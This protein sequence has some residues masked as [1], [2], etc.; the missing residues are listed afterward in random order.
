MPPDPVRAAWARRILAFGIDEITDSGS[1]SRSHGS[2]TRCP[3]NSPERRRH[4]QSVPAGAAGTLCGHALSMAPEIRLSAR[5]DRSQIPRRL[6]RR[7]LAVALVVVLG[8][9]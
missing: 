6:L 5:L 3:A 7:T 9:V 2:M 8:V 1:E 4:T